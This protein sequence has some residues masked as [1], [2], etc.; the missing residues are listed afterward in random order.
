MKKVG[1]VLA[2]GEGKR[3]V[4]CL[5]AL[6]KIVDEIVYLDD[7]S[8]DQTL[9]FVYTVQRECR[10]SRIIES[11]LPDHN[12]GRDR[13]LLLEAGREIGGEVFVVLDVDEAFAANADFY[14][15]EA[16]NTLKPGEVVGAPWTH[17][18]RSPWHYRVDPCVWVNNVRQVIF[19][20]DGVSHYP[21]V[22]LHCV[23][24]PVNGQLF[25][26]PPEI[27]LLHFQF[28]YWPNVVVKQAWYQ[29]LE[30]RRGQ[31][32]K[33]YLNREYGRALDE[34]GLK[35][36]PVNPD[37]FHPFFVEQDW[38]MLYHWRVQEMK[39]WRAK[40]PAAFEGLLPCPYVD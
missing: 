23:R 10:V 36:E 13:N 28:V 7:N 32:D 33:A 11:H 19:C 6:A 38:M 12:E 15:S 25:T 31:K 9:D 16:L 4:H 35:T 27:V 37:W 18:W 17:V 34:T 24:V 3:I 39:A 2:K 30:I 22:S 5:R 21:D 29:F 14:L 8:P 1:L 40:N 20:D 26:L